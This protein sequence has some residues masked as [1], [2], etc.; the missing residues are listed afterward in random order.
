MPFLCLR[1]S[2]Q[3]TVQINPLDYVFYV[4]CINAS[5]IYNLGSSGDYITMIRITT[6]GAAQ[7]INKYFLMIS[8]NRY[9]EFLKLTT[10]AVIYIFI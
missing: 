4:F 1:R 8:N 2:V 3:G 10:K 6:T 5:Y 9:K 7:T